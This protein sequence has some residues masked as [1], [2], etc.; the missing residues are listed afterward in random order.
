LK[1]NTITA[2]EKDKVDLFKHSKY[3][4]AVFSLLVG[5]L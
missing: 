1:N 3:Y 4:S 5:P 2:G